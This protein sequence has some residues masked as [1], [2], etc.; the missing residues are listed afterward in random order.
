MAACAVCGAAPQQEDRFCRIC[1]N[2][3]QHEGLSLEKGTPDEGPPVAEPQVWIPQTD[4]ESAVAFGDALRAG[5]KPPPIRSEIATWPGESVIAETP[6]DLWQYTGADVSYRS[7]GFVALGSPLLLVA[8]L[9]GSLAYNAHQ[10]N[11][12]QQ[13]AAAQWRMMNQGTLIFTSQRVA[14]AG[15]MGWLDMPYANIRATGQDGDGTV[16]FF[17]GSPR[18]KMRMWNPLTH[19]VLLRYLAYGDV[20]P[21]ALPPA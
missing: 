15:S 9:A 2:H 4:W 10:K 21:P 1:G 20:P 17:D 14:I 8:S 5:W 3:V 13:Q 16:L 19:F 12:A 11:K 6:G 7:G 18:L